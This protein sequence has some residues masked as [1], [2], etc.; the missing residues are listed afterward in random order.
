[1]TFDDLYARALIPQRF[2]CCNVWLQP[3]TLDHAEALDAL[4]LWWPDDPES[5]RAAAFIC[6]RPWS[7]ALRT[8]G[9]PFQRTRLHLWMLWHGNDRL[10][11]HD[12]VAW[13]AY[14]A[15]HREQAVVT[16][17][18]KQDSQP[19]T[20]WLT[21]LRVVACARLGYQPETVGEQLLAKITNEYHALSEME[22][23][24]TVIRATRSQFN[25]IAKEKEGECRS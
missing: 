24:A 15:H 22:C 23:A 9:H 25:E 4:G 11:F 20:P 17:R 6:S 7:K 16:F 12:W 5:L 8:I 1:M 10:R 21:H 13:R 2:R 19:G 14:V 3:L 18:T